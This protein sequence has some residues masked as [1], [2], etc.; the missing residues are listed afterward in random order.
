MAHHRDPSIL[1]FL[2]IGA[3]W[4]FFIHQGF[5]CSRVGSPKGPMALLG[6]IG[7]Q[8]WGSMGTGCC[9]PVPCASTQDN[10]VAELALTP[11][12]RW[13]HKILT[14]CPKTVLGGSQRTD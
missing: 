4:H 11:G 1:S 2:A 8:E 9:C 12:Q 6:T 13:L 7:P 5:S 14:V 10:A 3:G